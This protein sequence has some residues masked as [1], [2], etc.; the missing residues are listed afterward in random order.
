MNDRV[1]L[2]HEK[3]FACADARPC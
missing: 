2:L 1:E 3:P